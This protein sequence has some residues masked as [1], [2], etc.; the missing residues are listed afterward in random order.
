V[1]ETLIIVPTKDPHSEPACLVLNDLHLTTAG[2]SR[3]IVAHVDKRKPFNY[4]NAVNDAV[5]THLA[6]ETEFVCLWNDD[7]FPEP[8]WLDR[9]LRVMNENPT[10]SVLTPQILNLDGS[11]QSIGAYMRPRLLTNLNAPLFAIRTFGVANLFRTAP[12]SAP[13]LSS[14]V[15]T[16]GGTVQLIRRSAWLLLNGY[17]EDFGL[18]DNDTD[19]SLRC[20]ESY[21]EIGVC[22]GVRIK[23]VNGQ[24]REGGWHAQAKERAALWANKWPKKR[25]K[26]AIK[27]NSVRHF[28]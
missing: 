3:Q 6:P 20:H 4:S 18:W 27:P 16:I 1:P 14:E 2:L 26:Q 5:R 7:A 22:S 13:T 9:L 24:S 28:A 15:V 10:L 25:L 19:F 17:D 12:E 23:H 8:Y 21:L 11:P